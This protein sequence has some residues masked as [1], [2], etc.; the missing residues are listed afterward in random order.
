MCLASKYPD[1]VPLKK[2]HAE[3]VAEAMCEKFSRTDAPAELLTDQGTVFVGKL[4]TQ[5]CERWNIQKLT[6]SRYYP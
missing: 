1:A 3:T 6:T 4:Q 5:L 2:V